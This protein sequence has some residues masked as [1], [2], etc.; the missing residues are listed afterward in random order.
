MIW[1]VCIS[2]IL[3]GSFCFLLATCSILD[4]IRYFGNEW[5]S[6]FI[7]PCSL[8]RWR[9]NRTS[10]SHNPAIIYLYGHRVAFELD[11]NQTSQ[12]ECQIKSAI[13]IIQRFPCLS[14]HFSHITQTHDPLLWPSHIAIYTTINSNPR[15]TCRR[16]SQAKVRHPSQSLFHIKYLEIL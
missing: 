1:H 7:V 8:D 2:H 9:M 10:P 5:H 12:H 16:P 4:W 6:S 13:C 11:L 3:E 14:L 15:P